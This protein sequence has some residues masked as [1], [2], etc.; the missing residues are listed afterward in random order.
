MKSMKKIYTLAAGFLLCAGLVSCEMKDEIFGGTE[1]AE[2]GYLNLGVAVNSSENTVVTRAEGDGVTDDGENTGSAVS[3]D[4]FPVDIT[5]TTNPH[6]SRSFASYADLL[7]ENPI[8]LSVGTYTVTA[9]SNLTLEKKMSVPYYEGTSEAPLTI[10]KGVESEAKVVCKMKNT[11]IQMKYNSEFLANFDTWTI[12]IDDGTENSNGEGNVLTFTE[13]DKNP[14]AVYWL[15]AENKNKISVNITATNMDGETITD[16]RT[17][18]KPTGGNTEFW[19]GGD[20]LTITMEG[21]TP[22]PGNPSGVTGIDISVDVTFDEEEET[23]DVP[24]TPG[25]GEGEDEPSEPEPEDSNLDISITPDTYTLPTDMEKTAEVS[26]TTSAANGLTS[27]IVQITPDN[28]GFGQALNGVGLIYEIDFLNGAE[29]IDNDNLE[30]IVSEIAP[31]LTA[32]TTGSKS[33]TFP[34]HSF[35][36]AINNSGATSGTGHVFKITVKDADGNTAE[37]SITVAVSE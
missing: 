34:V 13:S 14:A 11:K 12:T 36:E 19:T 24:V 33:Y 15:I 35:F 29:I 17:L 8:E 20:A 27:V 4:D 16:S 23:V 31:G 22:D 9:H 2:K 21:I 3:A 25:T 18:T 10:T 7:E 37:K 30:N 32:P 1:S 28:S 26:I 5:C 6:Y